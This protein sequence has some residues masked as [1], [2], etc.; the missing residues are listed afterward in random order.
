MYVW[1]IFVF[2]LFFSLYRMQLPKL[3]ASN[4]GRTSCGSHCDGVCIQNTAL[5]TYSDFLIIF[6]SNLD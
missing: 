4:G 5:I 2:V 3:K 1:L 6:C